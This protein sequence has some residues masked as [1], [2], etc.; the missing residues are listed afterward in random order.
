MDIA[1]S[2]RQWVDAYHR[3]D[4]T[5]I[6]ALAAP[7]LVVNDERRPTERF[8]FGLEVMRVFEDEQLTLSGDSAQFAARMIE[9]AATGTFVSRVTETWV[10]RMG[11]WQLQEARIATESQVPPGR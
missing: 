9:R 8:P 2:A 3:Q 5:E 1:T 11:Q 6:E 7:S 4:R 10:R